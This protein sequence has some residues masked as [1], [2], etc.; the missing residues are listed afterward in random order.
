MVKDSIELRTRILPSKHIR[1]SESLL[2]L[3]AIILDIIKTP[4]SIDELWFEFSKINNS[5]ETFPAYHDF[6]NLI[7]AINYLFII[8]AL[9][10]DINSKITNAIN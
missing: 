7:L 2:G 9:S 3:G 5:K 10:I 1:L 6:D 8:G 4:R